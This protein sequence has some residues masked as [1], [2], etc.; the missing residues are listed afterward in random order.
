[1]RKELVTGQNAL[2]VASAQLEKAQLHQDLVE[3]RARE[4]SIILT[5]AKTSV[6][7]VLREGDPIYT[8]IPLNAPIEADVH[9]SARDIGFVRSGDKVTL[10]IDAFN[11]AEHGTAEG[12]I[13]WISEGAFFVSEDTNQPTDAYYHARVKIARSNFTDVPVNFRLIPGMTLVADINVGKRSLAR[14][15]MEGVVRGA[16]EAMREP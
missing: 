6:G 14:Y 4:D 5:L 7:A 10:K 15:L 3:L 1:L 12:V 16:G 13:E 9:I 2:D 11:Y 8:A